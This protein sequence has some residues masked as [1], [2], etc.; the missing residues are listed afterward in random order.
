[1]LAEV[2]DELVPRSGRRALDRLLVEDAEAAGAHL[3]LGLVRDTRAEDD[4]PDVHGLV[5][6]LLRR[7]GRRHL[8]SQGNR[9]T[10]RAN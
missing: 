5:L 8:F 3:L 9:Q 6:V 1:M 10:A 4:H 7:L 2:V